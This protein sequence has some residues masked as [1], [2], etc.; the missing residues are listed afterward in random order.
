MNSTINRMF[1][2]LVLVVQHP[3]FADMKN[4][5]DGKIESSI[6]VECKQMAMDYN[7]VSQELHDFKRDYYIIIYLIVIFAA[8]GIIMCYLMKRR[9]GTDPGW[10]VGNFSI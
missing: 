4:Q 2:V 8:L 7:K 9:N 6:G 1:L 10:R 5:D 3:S